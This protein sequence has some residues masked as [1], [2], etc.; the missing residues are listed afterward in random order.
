MNFLLS[1]I[2]LKFLPPYSLRLAVL[3]ATVLLA[4]GCVTTTDGPFTAKVDKVKAAEQYVQLGIAYYQQREYEIAIQRLNRALESNP[5]M[6]EA[7][8]VLGL[9][10]QAQNEMNVAEEKYL[11]AL[12]LNP[13]F[14]RGRTYYA[15]FLY[16]LE[17]FPQALDQFQIAANDV[18]YPSRA[19]IFSNIGLVHVRLDQIEEAIAAYEKALDIRRDQ[20][21][22]M[23]ALATLYHQRSNYDL[24]NGYYKAFRSQVR[25]RNISHTAQSLKL[26]IDL[27][28]QRQDLDEEASLLLLL[29]NLYPDSPEYQ[30]IK[31]SD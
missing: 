15:A 7:Y 31:E 23:L 29:K 28:R 12:S 20:P 30:A 19:Q 9:V 3:L 1:E 21:Q 8:S 24:S 27:A 13:K 11:K 5:N 6:P 17:R 22:V 10:Y 16:Q 26:G 14:T 4:S 2:A 25:A 18:A